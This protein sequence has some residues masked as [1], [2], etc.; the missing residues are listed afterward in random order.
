MSSGN[1]GLAC[2]SNARYSQLQTLSY[3]LAQ[4]LSQLIFVRNPATP[5]YDF[6]LRNNIFSVMY[7]VNVRTS[8]VT[9]PG[10]MT[11]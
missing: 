4:R 8:G 6:T 10:V 7:A 5:C 1:Y 9:R 2:V 11:Q 3:L